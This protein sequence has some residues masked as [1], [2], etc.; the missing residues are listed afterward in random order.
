MPYIPVRI[1]PDQWEAVYAKL[2]IAIRKVLDPATTPDMQERIIAEVDSWGFP[3]PSNEI[4]QA[5]E[6]YMLDGPDTP[7][8]AALQK[9]LRQEDL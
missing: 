5:A 2:A 8:G 1:P 4:R 7:D 6:T 9:A 3:G